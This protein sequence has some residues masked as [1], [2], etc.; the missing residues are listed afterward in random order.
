LNNSFSLDHLYTNLITEHEED[1]AAIKQCIAQHHNS[2]IYFPAHEPIDTI[3]KKIKDSISDSHNAIYFDLKNAFTPKGLLSYLT[4]ELLKSSSSKLTD[5]FEFAN[6]YMPNL[7]PQFYK[8]GLLKTELT[9]N[10][11]INEQT[12]YTFLRDLL[13]AIPLIAQETGK[14]FLIIFNNYD[15]IYTIDKRLTEEIFRDKIAKQKNI[16]YIFACSNEE[17]IAKIFDKKLA[18]NY[19]IKK[20]QV[21]KPLS[22]E[23]KKNYILTTF[24]NNGFS[25][26]DPVIEQIIKKTSNLHN[27]F[28]LC[29][30]LFHRNLHKKSIST[31][32]IKEIIQEIIRELSPSYLTIWS[33]L[34]PHQKTLLYA[35]GSKGGNQIFSAK[36][37]VENDLGSAPS[38]QTSINA[39]IKKSILAKKEKEFYFCDYFFREW[40]LLILS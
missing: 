40:I 38:V 30:K 34:S 6:K 26:E 22:E 14:P 35:L 15:N 4:K 16:N 19:K 25:I 39:L 27:I 29:H 21:I 12:I 32:A 23:T 7:K 9:I 1:I 20:M 31:N 5:I 8:Q 28:L 2:F 3:L 24:R 13:D 10:Y 37:L 11:S 36:F 18:H 17:H 33:N